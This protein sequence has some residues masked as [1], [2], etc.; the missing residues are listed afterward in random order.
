VQIRKSFTFEAAHV[1]PHHP[2][3]CSRL[4]GHSYRL[5]VAVEG[6]LRTG[7]PAAG[8]IE[9][10]EVV[11]STVKDAV[12]AQLDHRSLNELIDNPTAEHIA[13][14]IWSRLAPTLP[15]LAEIVLWE[16]RRACVVLRKGDPLTAEGNRRTELSV[17][18][19]ASS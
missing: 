14:W 11:T 2:G 18:E 12:I 16:T 8:M 4:H 7:G 17:Q 6:S 1:L 13:L 19:Q 5:D 3:K 10:F 9:D 15:G